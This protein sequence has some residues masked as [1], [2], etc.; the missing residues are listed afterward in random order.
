MWYSKKSFLLS[1]NSLYAILEDSVAAAEIAAAV[2]ASARAAVGPVGGF[3]AVVVLRVLVP[4]PMIGVARTGTGGAVGGIGGSG[5]G[6]P[7]PW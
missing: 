3:T 4:V 5:L 6:R 2:V 7:I 1:K